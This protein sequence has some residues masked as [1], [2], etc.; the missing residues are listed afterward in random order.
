MDASRFS[1]FSLPRELR[2]D[3]I[4]APAPLLSPELDRRIAE[5]WEQENQSA[6]GSLFNGRLLSLVDGD[7]GEQLARGSLRAGFTEYRLFAAQ[8]ADPSLYEQLRVRPLAVTGMLWTPDG[9]LAFGLRAKNVVQDAGLWE[10]MPSGGL[11]PAARRA[12]GRIDPGLQ[13]F[14]ELREETN[15]PPDAV[16]GITPLLLLIDHTTHVH[17]VV[18]EARSL[19]GAGA[20]ASQF[21]RR[22]TD[23]YQDFRLL[24]AAEWADFLASNAVAP[25]TR[26]IL[27]AWSRMRGKR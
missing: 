26:A 11:S 19:A 2:I 9:S 27:E 24:P 22:T 1:T 5:L 8:H 3:A 15:L 25:G 13:F 18:V 16:A 12:D 14:E 17:D 21:A 10:L 7:A 20:I 23:E 4:D 6:D